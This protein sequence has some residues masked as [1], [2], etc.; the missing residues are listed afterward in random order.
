MRK[1]HQVLQSSFGDYSS[2]NQGANQG[3][4]ESQL[5]AGTPTMSPGYHKACHH[6]NAGDSYHG[7]VVGKVEEFCTQAALI[8]LVAA[9]IFEERNKTYSFNVGTMI[10][11]PRTASAAHKT[12]K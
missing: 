2:R 7:F 11:I 1:S 3:K 8:C 9:K 12:A 10:E 4:R 5:H 6:Q